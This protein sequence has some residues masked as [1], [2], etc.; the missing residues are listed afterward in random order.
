MKTTTLFIL[1]LIS[2]P[3]L[4]QNINGRISSS[5]YMFERFDTVDVSNDYMRTFQLLNLNINEGSFSLKSYINL[6]ND[7]TNDIAGDPHV[8]FYNL[9]LEGRNLFD[10]F[11]IR[12]G[13]QPLFTSVAGGMFDGVNLD[14]KYSDFK[15]TGYYGGNVPA[16]QKLKLTENFDDNYILGGKFTTTAVENLQFSLGYIK[17][18][19]LREEYLASRLDENLNPINFLISNNSTQYEF[20]SADASYQLEHLLSADAGFEY[21]LNFDQPSKYEFLFS[22]NQVKDLNL[23]FYY[24]YREPKIR[25]NSIFSV[26]DYGNTQ[27]IELGGSYKIENCITVSGR[28]GNINYRDDESS[29]RITVGAS[30]DFGNITY[31]KNL[32]YAGELDAVSFYSAYTFL[33]G[34]FT[35]SIGLSLTNYKLSEDS[36]KNNLTTLLAGLNFRPWRELSFDVQGQYMDNKIYKN[37]YRFFF[38]INYWFNTNLNLM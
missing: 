32:G 11:T 24:N 20:I 25:Y 12:F 37:D 10:L 9:Y 29:C 26:F 5:L 33:E 17:K 13:R 35:P 31:R 7:F 18:N 38:R 6:E 21:D 15:L 16:Y 27:E 22:Y 19:F 23:E 14:V 28:F 30:S 3:L 34:L 2:T 36:E 4:S 1:L 8:R